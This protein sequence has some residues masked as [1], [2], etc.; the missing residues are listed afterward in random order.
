[1]EIRAIVRPEETSELASLSTIF[2]ST[3]LDAAIEHP[4][5]SSIIDIEHR[6]A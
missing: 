6:S 1:M 4:F 3:S 2:H 5:P